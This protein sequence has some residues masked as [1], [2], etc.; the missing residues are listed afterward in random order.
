MNS[1]NLLTVEIVIPSYNRLNILQETLNKI[2]LLYPHTKICL[3]LQG[4]M[5]DNHFLSQLKND[6]NLRIEELPVPSTTQ[7]L[8]HCITTSAADII[9]ILDDDAFPCFGWLE[10]HVKAF[11]NNPDLVYTSGRI[12]ELTRKRPAFSEWIRIMTEWF[13]G[14]FI[15]NDKKLNGRIIGWINRLGLLFGN[16]NQPGTCKINSPREGNMGI[17][18]ELF[19]KAGRFNSA[20]KG[21]AWG[22]GSDFG[23]RLAKDGSY[24][25]YSG[26]AIIIHHEATAGG[27]REIK[28]AQWLS[29]FIYNHTLLIK[30]LGPQ[31]WV[32]SVPRLLKKIIS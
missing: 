10:E 15:N 7:T 13:F 3:G 25:Q 29:D 21:N 1:K 2:R 12:V 28:K 31:A 6:S 20:F 9:L 16:Y 27:S 32:G 26:N 8:N 22:F 23:L 30:H 18:R 14:L 17:R 5:P 11:A 24:G 19:L 4:P